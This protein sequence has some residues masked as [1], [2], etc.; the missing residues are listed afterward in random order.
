MIDTIQ[1]VTVPVSILFLAVA[2]AGLALR[3]R[4][5]DHAFFGLY[6]V[7]VLVTDL[8]VVVNPVLFFQRAPY[9]TKELLLHAIQLPLVF[10]IARAAAHAHP[11]A[12]RVLVTTLAAIAAIGLG[13]FG[14]EARSL[15][16]TAAAYHGLP[17]LSATVGWMCAVVIAAATRFRVALPPLER[18]VLIAF[19]LYETAHA[20][21]VKAWLLR[22]SGST[23]WL[24]ENLESVGM[25]VTVT[26]VAVAGLWALLVWRRTDGPAP[27]SVPTRV[28]GERG[29]AGGHLRD[30]LADRRY[31]TCWPKISWYWIPSLRG[32]R[33]PQHLA[34]GAQRPAIGQVV[35]AKAT[36]TAF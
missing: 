11:R 32:L 34:G 15:T 5:E 14:Y 27:S 17:V 16:Y 13:V 12:R 21:L 33:T 20:A 10:S 9:L 30:A 7:V 22:R 1:A 4:A 18:S 8:F 2:L 35:E 31:G 6:V 24:G 25:V 23:A 29:T 28:R 3:P 26:W 36:R 19:C